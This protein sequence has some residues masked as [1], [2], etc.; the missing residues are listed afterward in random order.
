MCLRYFFNI[1]SLRVRCY[2]MTSSSLLVSLQVALAIFACIFHAATV[3]CDRSFKIFSSMNNSSKSSHHWI[4]PIGH[5]KI[6]V[7]V[8]GGGHYRSVQDAVNA[9]PDNNRKNVLVQ[10]NAGCYKYIYTPTI[11]SSLINYNHS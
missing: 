5:R 4:G 10:I 7:D 9:V 8:N 6:T 11:K 3:T 1:C 2:L